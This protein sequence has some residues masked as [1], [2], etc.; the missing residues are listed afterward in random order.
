MLIKGPLVFRGLV[1]MLAKG[2]RQNVLTYIP[3][4][5]DYKIRAKNQCCRCFS[6]AQED[7]PLMTP[8]SRSCHISS[9]LFAFVIHTYNQGHNHLYACS[10]ALWWHQMETFSALHVICARNSLVTG[11][12]AAQRPVTRRLD[13]FFCLR[14]NKRFSKQSW[15]WWFETPSRTLWRNCNGHVQIA[16][17]SDQYRFYLDPTRKL[18]IG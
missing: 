8:Y 17:T 11:E 6:M 9:K 18:W 1:R 14:R 4:Y 7:I 5:F 13:V 16:N 10:C 3:M 15:G 12:F 2:F